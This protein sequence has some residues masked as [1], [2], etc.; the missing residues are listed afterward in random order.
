MLKA[1]FR[2]YY[3]AGKT[4]CQRYHF[5][6]FAAEEICP[7]V[8]VVEIFQLDLLQ[9]A[10]KNQKI[11]GDEIRKWKTDLKEHLVARGMRS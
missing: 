5:I 6:K 11:F 4:F 3:I 9:T 10:R 8:L 2:L 7:T 1:R